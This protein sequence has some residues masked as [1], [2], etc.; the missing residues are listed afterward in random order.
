MQPRAERAVAVDGARQ[1]ADVQRRGRE[2]APPLL[3]ARALG[4][5]ESLR[6][7]ADWLRSES[8]ALD[9]PLATHLRDRG[10]DRAAIELMDVAANYNALERVS[11]LDALRRDRLRRESDPQTLRVR[12]GAQRLPEAMA[13]ALHAEVEFGRRVVAVEQDATGVAVHTEDG[14]RIRGARV[15]LAVPAPC[16]PRLAFMPELPK[17]QA[18]VFAA[19][20]STA[21]T[22]V[23]FRP[24][25]AWWETDGLPPGMWVDGTIERMF[26]VPGDGPGGVARLIV[27]I[28]GDGARR[29]DALDADEIARYAEWELR[30]LRPASRGQLELLA[31]KSWGADPL[32][33]GAYAEIAA[34]RC[35]STAEWAAK[36]HGRV[37]FAGEHTDFLHL[38]MEAALAS[39]E[40]AAREMLAG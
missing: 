33:R 35:A 5:D 40:R 10:Y 27:W 22:T 14:Q 1:V 7:A 21:I 36:A 3:L 23:H 9:I 8:A 37:H 6:R 12:D 16:L 13:G 29:L 39:A 26:P 28:N 31:V 25:S 30:S 32:A 15:L 24:R 38:G 18:A 4:E 11:A 17:V 34:G 2:T 19:R 20:E